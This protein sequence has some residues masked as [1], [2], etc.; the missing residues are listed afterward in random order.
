MLFASANQYA[1]SQPGTPASL[2]VSSFQNVNQLGRYHLQQAAQAAQR[3]NIVLAAV[4]IALLCLYL[5]S[6]ARR[7]RR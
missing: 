2:G 4:V 7:T 5:H 6:R 3:P 1:P